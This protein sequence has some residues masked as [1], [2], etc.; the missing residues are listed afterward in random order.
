MAMLAWP[1]AALFGRHR[2]LTP[3][4]FYPLLA[5]ALTVSSLAWLGGVALLVQVTHHRRGAGG[6]AHG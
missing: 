4:H 3:L 1:E 5:F 2:G 6:D